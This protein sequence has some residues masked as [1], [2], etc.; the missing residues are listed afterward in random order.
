MTSRWCNRPHG[1]SIRL[2]AVTEATRLLG[3]VEHSHDI[4]SG[5]HTGDL[6]VQDCMT[7]D[8]ITSTIV[9]EFHLMSSL[10]L[11]PSPRLPCLSIRI[12]MAVEGLHY[13]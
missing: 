2:P 9:L 5:H 1:R 6:H 11:Y 12:Q 13:V 10:H 4:E 7:M 3:M 8:Q